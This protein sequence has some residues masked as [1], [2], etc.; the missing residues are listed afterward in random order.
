MNLDAPWRFNTITNILLQRV[1]SIADRLNIDFALI[2]KERKKANEVTIRMSNLPL[3]HLTPY[4]RFFTYMY[5]HYTYI[6]SFFLAFGRH[7]S[8]FLR[9]Y[10]P[11]VRCCSVLI[12]NGLP[13]KVANMVLICTGSKYG[14]GR[15]RQGK[16]CNSHRRHGRHVW[17]YCTGT[18]KTTR[19]IVQA[20]KYPFLRVNAT[21]CPRLSF[22]RGWCFKLS[23]SF[24][25]K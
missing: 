18:E 13:V 25:V 14:A 9:S 24:Q 19:I 15:W 4:T 21:W 2:H 12:N 8:V 22:F 10:Q 1:T 20:Q 23:A 5:I 6:H 16:N 7:F 11:L 17:D 3:S